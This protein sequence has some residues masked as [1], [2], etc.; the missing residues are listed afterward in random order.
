[1]RDELTGIG[2]RRMLQMRLDLAWKEWRRR[3]LSFG[4][5]M[6]DVDH[7]KKVNDRLGH[8]MGDRVLQMVA[9]SLSGG[10]RAH[11]FVGRWGGEEFLALI[12]GEDGQQ[13][14]AGAAERLR[15][16]VES[17][18]IFLDPHD[19]QMEDSVRVTISLGAALVQ[20][21]DTLESLLARAD[22]ALYRGKAG[23]RNRV[24]LDLPVAH[25]VSGVESA[26][27]GAV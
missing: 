12:G 26:S 9:N 11:D 25:G 7:F 10:L 20:P 17:S 4:V 8:E 1:M 5:I 27:M 21:G 22:R 2:S 14:L 15:M 3:G 6:I 23:G 19:R 18:I 16:L 13:G 24:E